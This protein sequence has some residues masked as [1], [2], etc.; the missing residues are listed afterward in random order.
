MQITGDSD[1]FIGKFNIK[2]KTNPS[3]PRFIIKRNYEMINWD[4]LKESLFT[5]PQ[6]RNC[7]NLEDP[8]LICKTIQDTVTHHL[9]QEAPTK[10]VQISKKIPVFLSQE[11]KDLLKERD[12]TLQKAKE[13][14]DQDTWR[15]FR[16][17]RNTC[18]K[19]MSKDKNNYIK[20]KLDVNNNEHEKWETTKEILGWKNRINPSI[21]NDRGTTVT[22]PQQITNTLNHSLLSKVAKIV[23]EIPPSNTDPIDNYSKLMKDK[24]CKLTIQ[25]IGI[26][27]LRKLVSKLK[28]SRSAGV[29]GLSTKL[30]KKYS[31]KLNSQSYK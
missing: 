24:E 31:K 7:V 10:K 18:H 28:S 27:E 6:L 12:V 29:D 3:I 1:H 25:P 14:N 13:D 5:N 19:N 22:S 15:K 8:S 23:R 16:H 20:S 9:D 11:T 17:L 30:L 2:T 26:L 4:Q 21:L